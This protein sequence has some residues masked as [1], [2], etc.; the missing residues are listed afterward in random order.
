MN[1]L[2]LPCSIITSLEDMEILEQETAS[3]KIV[4]SKP[5]QVKWM[6]G[7]ESISDDNERFKVSS[8]DSSLEHTLTISDITTEDGGIFTAEVDDK[9]Y[10]TITSSATITVKGRP[11]MGFSASFECSH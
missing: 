7:S 4:L 2:E 8:S 3:L 5:R 9:D 1:I 11:Y 6:K 10:G